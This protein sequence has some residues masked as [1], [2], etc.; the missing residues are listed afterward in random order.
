VSRSAPPD[1][2]DALPRPVMAFHIGVSG[3][4]SLPGADIDGLRAAAA[5]LFRAVRTEALAL[6][7]ADQAAAIPLYAPAPP[8]L[9]CVC[10]LAEGADS[11]FAEAALDEAWQLV[12]MLPF[13]PDAFAVD[14]TG[15]ALDRYHRLL[16]RADVV[17]A[18]DGD[19]DSDHA[20]ADTG[21]Q[22]VE[23]SDILLTLWD[24]R[25]AQGLGGT[26]DV[27]RHAL[28]AGLPVA[29]LPPSGP[30]V[31]TWLGTI[32][33]NVAAMLHA[34]MLPPA[35][36]DGFPQAC[37]S[38]RPRGDGWAG[39][40]L[41]AYDRV[42]TIGL[43][44]SGPAP[45]ARAAF[46][47]EV[48]VLDPAF[49]S[50]DQLATEYAA[51]YRAAGL[52]RYALILPATLALLVGWYGT[53][54]LQPAGNLV[55]F[56]VLVF[57]VVFSTRGGWEPAQRRFLMYRALA[58]Y[59]R[60]ARILTPLRAVAQIP[61]AAA[62]EARAADWSSW[63]GRAVIRQ[64]GI[65]PACFDAECVAHAATFVRGEAESQVHFLLHRAA[66]FDAIAGRLRQIGVAL[67]IAGVAFSAVRAVLLLADA[68]PSAL[69]AFNELALVLPAMAPVFLG[70]LSFHEYSKL[71]TR[72]RAVAKALNGQ[73]AALGRAPPHRAAVLPITRRIVEVMLAER[74]DWRELMQSRTISAY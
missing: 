14:F 57:V 59:I 13:A 30:P 74:N 1:L 67:S 35:S 70:L 5:G 62:Y 65:I 40:V 15:A 39:T 63:Y 46:A 56:V 6:H 31:L 47:P 36:G 51:R 7:A 53:G 11:I 24:R 25:R 23:Q 45:P 73:I 33:T 19:R 20:Y 10:G 8:L 68:G 17:C 72:Y 22:I 9:R 16:A 37:F 49:R 66:R 44:P 18:L 28:Q 58:E 69:R 26:G 52:L 32:E 71:A 64:Q 4:R 43:T 42:V 34:A 61:G 41:R 27:V 54:R 38:D 12:A 2:P 48:A 55:D 3:H 50:A 60:N 29:V 21:D